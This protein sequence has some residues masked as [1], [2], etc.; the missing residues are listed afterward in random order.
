MK[1]AD[2]NREGRC[3]VDVPNPWPRAP[4]RLR[5]LCRGNETIAEALRSLGD[6]D[7]GRPYILENDVFRELH[8]TR[9]SAQSA[10][11]IADPVRLVSAYTRKM[12][13][14]LLFVPRPRRILMLGLGGGALAKYCHRHIPGADVTIV[15]PDAEVIALREEFCIPPDSGR[16]RV[17][18]ADGAAFVKQELGT[19]D[20]ILIDAFDSEGIAPSLQNESFYRALSLRL[21]PHGTLV[22][23]L[24]GDVH[25]IAAHTKLAQRLF[26]AQLVLVPISKADNVLLFGLRQP[27]LQ[28]VPDGIRPAAERLKRALNLDFPRYLRRINEGALIRLASDRTD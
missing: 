17:V 6:G 23:N 12:M 20:V 2:S 7:A 4:G 14:F 26:D 22:M 25:R 10:M 3:W 5:I 16:F 21:E 28:S 24:L 15:E 1:R 19:Y 8:F 13:A 9:I 27:A 18:C 11:L